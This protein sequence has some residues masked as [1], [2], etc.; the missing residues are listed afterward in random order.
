M[1]IV[2]RIKEQTL[3]QVTELTDAQLVTE[4][5]VLRIGRTGIQLSYGTLPKPEWRAFPPVEYADP[6]FLVKDDSSAFY[7]AFEGEKYIGGAAVTIHPN[8]W[9]DVLDLRVDAAFRRQGA[10][11]MLLDKCMSFAEKRELYG[12][13]VACTDAN[14]GMCRFLEHEGFTLH[15]FDQMV[16]S[17]LPEERVKPRSR[18]ASLLYFYRLNQKG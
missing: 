4:E 9:A 10:G 11:R 5:A 14:P 18:R 8:G 2:R 7:G 1:L 12:L 16:L 13:R 6:A 17:Q 3:H 15:G